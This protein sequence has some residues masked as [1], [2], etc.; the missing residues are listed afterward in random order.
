MSETTPEAPKSAP[1]IWKE[2]ADP[3]PPELVRWRLQGK[4][5]ADGKARIVCYVDVR[6]V[7]DRLNQV[8]GI[9]GWKTQVNVT[10]Q[11]NGVAHCTL[12][13]WFPTRS[14]WV[15][16][17][18]VGSESEQKDPGDRTKA[19]VSDS[20]KRAAVHFGIGRY[21]YTIGTFRV[22]V[23]GNG[24]FHPPELPLSAL[25]ESHRPLGQDGANQ[26]H[27]LVTQYA[28]E[29]ATEFTKV[30]GELY[31]KHGNYANTIPL[32]GIARRHARAMMQDVNRCLGELAAGKVP[33]DLPQDGKSLLAKVKTLGQWA[34]DQKIT[35][36]VDEVLAHVISRGATA[37]YS[38][39]V[40][41]W[42][43]PQIVKAVDWAKSFVAE[44]QKKCPK[45]QDD[46]KP[47]QPQKTGNVKT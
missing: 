18:D 21:L 4:P 45:D 30:M 23:D 37:G 25:P 24:N 31:K 35:A 17:D 40:D 22:P 15:S 7:A 10:D 39:S 41:E 44:K 19:A 43:G 29:A 8:L 6:T 1:Q 3:F 28:K 13:V 14:E 36:N 46:K 5:A 12:S 2:L 11:A 34:F 26:L 20:I 27:K 42:K 16:R 47:A 32:H 9:D 38:T 33:P